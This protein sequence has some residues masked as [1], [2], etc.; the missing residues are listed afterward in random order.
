MTYSTV[1]D[2]VNYRASFSGPSSD[3]DF[4]TPPACYQA[5]ARP[6][7]CGT[8]LGTNR[9]GKRRAQLQLT[10]LLKRGESGYVV[11]TCPEFPGCVGQGNDRDEALES[12]TAGIAGILRLRAEQ[13]APE[14]LSEDPRAV[15]IDLA[16]ELA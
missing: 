11:A 6:R 10:I 12:I 3:P 1:A 4:A 14:S 13:A 15:V 8:R 7:Q 16:P 9:V 5:S 2:S